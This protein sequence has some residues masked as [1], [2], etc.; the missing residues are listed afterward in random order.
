M[1][2]GAVVAPVAGRRLRGAGMGLVAGGAAVLASALI[3]VS[4]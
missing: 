3:L 4:R 2:V 1:L